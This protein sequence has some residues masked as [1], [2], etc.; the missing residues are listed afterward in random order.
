M[1]TVH[2]F[3]WSDNRQEKNTNQIKMNLASVA[4]LVLLK[5]V[6]LIILT[7]ISIYY[8]GLRFNPHFFRSSKLK[9]KSYRFAL[10][11]VM[12]VIIMRYMKV[13]HNLIECIITIIECIK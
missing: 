10:V 2:A 5:I 7:R 6:I 12:C 13:Y 1:R 11:A 4:F 8:M 9:L 3:D